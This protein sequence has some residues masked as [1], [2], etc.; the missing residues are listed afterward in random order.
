MRINTLQDGLYQSR[1]RDERGW[2]SYLAFL[3]WPF[4]SIILAFKNWDKPWAKNVFWLFCVF[5]GLTFVI[6]DIGGADSDR[7]ARLFIELAHSNSGLKDLISTFYAA[8]SDYA[9]IVLPLIMFILSRVTDNPG[10]LFVVFGLIS[11]YFYSRNIWYVFERVNDRFS[12]LLILFMFTFI[13]LNPIWNINAFRFHI[14]AQIFLFGTLPYLL[15][16]KKKGLIWSALSVLAHFSFVFPVAILGLYIVFRN[17]INLYLIFFIIT[18][19][20]SEINLE[21]V[22]S[23]LSFLPDFL[24][25]EVMRYTNAE[26]AEYIGLA[27]Q[28]LP[29]FITYSSLGVKLV[30]YTLVALTFLSAR[31]LLEERADLKN[32]LSFALLFYAFANILSIIPSGGRFIVV[33]NTF[34]FPF[35]IISLSTFPRL[36]ESLII[37][38][39]SYPFLLLFCTVSIRMGMDHFSIMTIIG[40]PITAAFYSDPLT[41][42]AEIERLF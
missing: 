11:G 31:A 12:E 24:F 7:Y 16:G 8:G 37:K 2:Y 5:F 30:V 1:F 23:S 10:I 29:W 26:Y 36:G 35:F 34:M 21:W 40:N 32:L 25:M 38:A 22:Q 33:A 18:A 41:L 4:L 9:D 17:R 15:E 39:V 6:A 14:A 3:I 20:I 19:F 42:M 28:E 13:I 27:S